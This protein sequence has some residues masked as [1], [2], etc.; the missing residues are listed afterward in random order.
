M[1]SG[2]AVRLRRRNLDSMD[3]YA[4][5]LGNLRG[6][7]SGG[8]RR[9]RL[10]TKQLS[11]NIGY[12]AAGFGL[13]LLEAPTLRRALWLR[14]FKLEA[15]EGRDKDEMAKFTWTIPTERVH[16]RWSVG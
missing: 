9:E 8:C 3:H 15:A 4:E 10:T 16:T 5:G 14:K 13:A 1:Q 7:R 6:G 2:P 11:V 12:H